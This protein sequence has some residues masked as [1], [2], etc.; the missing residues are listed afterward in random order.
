[1]KTIV[2]GDIHGRQSWKDILS[3]EE[4]DRV[5]FVG[6]YLDTHEEI[7]GT[8]QLYNLKAIIELKKTSEKPVILLIG[9]HDHHYLPGIQGGNTSGYQPRMRPSFEQVF[10]ENPDMFQMAFCDEHNNLMTHAGVTL[11]WLED[12]DILDTHP[13]TVAARINELFIHKPQAFYFYSLDF[14]GYGD[15]VRQS[16]IWVRPQSLY[17][18]QLKTN[19]IVGHTRPK[20]GK[21]NSLKSERQGFYLIDTI[22]QEWSDYLVITDGEIKVHTLIH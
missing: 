3:N 1:M 22:G 20:D 12:N 15:H 14:G 11:S 13:S 6:D 10:T 8:E 7:T 9:N 16:P 5:V 2:L 4:W 21:I 17:R 19:Q 18:N